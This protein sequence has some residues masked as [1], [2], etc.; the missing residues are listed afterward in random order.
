MDTDDSEWEYDDSE[1][2]DNPE[3]D[4]DDDTTMNVDDNPPIFV[5]NPT[6]IFNAVQANT[7]NVIDVPQIPATGPVRGQRAG[8]QF[9][10]ARVCGCVR[11]GAGGGRGHVRLHVRGVRGVRCG[12]RVKRWKSCCLRYFFKS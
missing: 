7:N 10:G 4:S 2:E 3:I 12:A 8:A 6:P 11:G 1:A 9:R 5:D